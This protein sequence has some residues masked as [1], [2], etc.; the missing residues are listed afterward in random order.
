MKQGFST[1]MARYFVVSRYLSRGRI[2]ALES[3]HVVK[4]FLLLFFNL[5]D[6]AKMF[7]CVRDYIILVQF[8]FILTYLNIV[9]AMSCKYLKRKFFLPP[10]PPVNVAGQFSFHQVLF[11]I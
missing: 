10:F 5:Q 4:E 2:Y 11:F 6:C 7:G 3:D 9:F 8:Y 1:M